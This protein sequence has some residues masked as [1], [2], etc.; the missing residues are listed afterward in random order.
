MSDSHQVFRDSYR[1]KLVFCAEGDACNATV[2]ITVLNL[3][4]EHPGFAASIA[5]R[6]IL[7][8]GLIGL[9]DVAQKLRANLVFSELSAHS[10]SI[11]R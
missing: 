11:S 6:G 1:L 3:H 10:I 8:Q 9:C 4:R 2:P 7:V 5:V